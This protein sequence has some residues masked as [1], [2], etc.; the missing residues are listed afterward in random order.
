MSQLKTGRAHWRSRMWK[1]LFTKDW[2]SRGQWKQTKEGSTELHGQLKV[3]LVQ[4]T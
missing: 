2:N 4:Q 1:N 3:Q